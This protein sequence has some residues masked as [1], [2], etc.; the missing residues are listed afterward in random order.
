MK[1]GTFKIEQTGFRL[2]ERFLKIIFDNARSRKVDEIYVTL[3][4]DREELKALEDLL[5]VWGFRKYGTKRTAD[6]NE[7]VLTKIM[8]SYNPNFSVKEN[9]P[10]ILFSN[11]QKYFFADSCEISYKFASR[12]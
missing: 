9:Y 8:H 3:F 1:V 5:S 4:E 11:R 10:N 12:F 2:G 7:V 6:K